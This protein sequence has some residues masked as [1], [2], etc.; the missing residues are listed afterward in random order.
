M[1]LPP[2]SSWRQLSILGAVVHVSLTTA[3][4]FVHFLLLSRI[5]TTDGYKAWTLRPIV[6]VALSHQC[7]C[8]WSVVFPTFHFTSAISRIRMQK[9][10]EATLA[11]L[12]W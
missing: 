4:H 6:F 1:L 3:I 2:S 10:F 5:S 7:I 11:E 12:G 8:L 9:D